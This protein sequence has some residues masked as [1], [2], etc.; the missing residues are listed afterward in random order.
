VTTSRIHVLCA[1]DADRNPGIVAGT[2]A[3]DVVIRRHLPAVEL[4]FFTPYPRDTSRLPGYPAVLDALDHLDELFDADAVIWWGDFLH[5]HMYLDT[6]ARNRGAGGGDRGALRRV[7]LAD[8]ARDDELERSLLFG[9]SLLFNTAADNA[10]R[11]YVGA[12]ARLVRGAAGVWMRDLYSASLAAELR[13]SLPT[14]P[15]GVDPVLLLDAHDH[16]VP[17]AADEPAGGAAGRR[18]PIGLFFGR[19]YRGQVRIARFLRAVQ[20]RFDAPMTWIPWGESGHFAPLVASRRYR[21]GRPPSHAPAD[22]GGLGSLLSAMSRCRFVVTDTY[23]FAMNSWALGTEAILVADSTPPKGMNINSGEELAWR[24]K[25]FE[26]YS[27]LDALDYFVHY[28][29]LADPRR[30]A[31]RVDRLATVVGGPAASDR[32]RTR[33]AAIGAG[34][35]AGLAAELQRLEARASA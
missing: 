3:A 9:G 30:R 26:A 6:V 31:R 14:V 28:D 5:A 27:T 19:S 18:R 1:A 22:G 24:D 8:G 12:L 21:T 20:R 33:I 13:G 2:M 16:G 17:S 11:D 23:H 4:T 35:E 10:D 7:L 34:A 32:V 15:L 25:R 29:E